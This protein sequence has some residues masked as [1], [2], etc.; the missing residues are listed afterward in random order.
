SLACSTDR[1]ESGDLVD[2]ALPVG[3]LLSTYI[4]EAVRRVFVD[5]DTS[6]AIGQV[7]LTDR[8]KECL[9]WAAEGKTTWETSQILGI[10]ER[11]VIFHLKNVA[12]KL[13]V[14]NRSQAV[15][16]AVS[17]LLITPRLG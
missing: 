3:H 13:N 16:R 11:T 2:E 6:I 1:P 8:E 12:Q 15:A 14:S 10:S 5:N 9:T 4:H 17:Q 7:Q